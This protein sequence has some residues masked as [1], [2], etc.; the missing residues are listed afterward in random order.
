MTTVIRIFTLLIIM[1]FFLFTETIAQS[2]S[3]GVYIS[4]DSGD[5]SQSGISPSIEVVRFENGIITGGSVNNYCFNYS[6]VK[7]ADCKNFESSVTILSGNMISTS[8]DMQIFD[9]L[10]DFSIP[11]RERYSRFGGLFSF[12]PAKLTIIKN[13]FLF[14][15]RIKNRIFIRVDD[16]NFRLLYNYYLIIN[17]PI[18]KGSCLFESRADGSWA[19]KFSNDLLMVS[20]FI[21]LLQYSG[22]NSKN[23]E[24]ILNKIDTIYSLLNNSRAEIVDFSRHPDIKL[25]ID[26]LSILTNVSAT[27]IWSGI[28]YFKSRYNGVEINGLDP[29]LILSEKEWTNA[30]NSS[31]DYKLIEDKFFACVEKLRNR[32]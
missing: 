3:T 20:D 1:N 19:N 32:P 26:E 8:S 31:A 24:I 9:G 21:A 29:N 15:N 12:E 25:N 11:E 5:L 14:S 27:S 16:F 4:I 30:I 13:G 22:V 23:K 28:R 10:K 17:Q 18:W 2:I 7:M 6:R